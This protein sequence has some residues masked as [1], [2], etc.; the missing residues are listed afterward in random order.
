MSEPEIIEA[1]VGKELERMSG[2]EIVAR[3]EL[4]VEQVAARIHKVQLA[5]REVMKEDVH[6][7]VI[8]GTDKKPTLLKPG[9]ELLCLLFRMA[10]SYKINESMEDD[11]HL[12]VNAVCSLQHIPTGD[13]LGE[14]VGMCTSREKKYAYRK[15]QRVCP[16]CGQPQVRKSKYDDEWYCWKREGGCGTTWPGDSEQGKAFEAT[17]VNAVDNPELPDT[18][19]TILKMAKKRALVDAVLTATAA[20]DVFTQD[21]EDHRAAAAEE[22]APLITPDSLT[23]LHSA[24]TV[25][26]YSDRWTEEN[27]LIYAARKYEREI[28][29]LEKLYEHEAAEILRGAKAFYEENPPVPDGEPTEPVPEQSDFEPPSG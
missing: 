9:A 26:A 3:D 27:V 5:L 14:G 22:K 28:P 12:T 21:A 15:G 7:G 2:A 16:N 4:T 6:Y 20:S 23:E 11:G 24:L 13:F 25:L 17:D 19:N 1:E 18:Y 29:S 8:P 10:P